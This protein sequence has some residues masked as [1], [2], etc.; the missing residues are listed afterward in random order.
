[1]LCVILLL[2]SPSGGVC[3]SVHNI[4][5]HHMFPCHVTRL[6]TACESHAVTG[7]CGKGR[8]WWF[9]VLLLQLQFL[10][11]STWHNIFAESV[12]HVDHHWPLGI[13]W[14]AG[15]DAHPDNNCWWLYLGKTFGHQ[16]K[17]NPGPAKGDRCETP[18]YARFFSAIVVR[19]PILHLYIFC[20][21]G[22]SGSVMA[23]VN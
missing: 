16:A 4:W 11:L 7:D 18:P 8:T 19:N 5:V 3:A 21:M 15:N 14:S 12:Q 22:T 10:L 13:S 1:M 17:R 23:R 6:S 2:I 20:T 9:I